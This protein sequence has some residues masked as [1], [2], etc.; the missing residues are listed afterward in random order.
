MKKLSSSYAPMIR[1][2]ADIYRN[3]AVVYGQLRSLRVTAEEW[4]PSRGGGHAIADDSDGVMIN[5]ILHPENGLLS[6]GEWYR[7]DGTEPVLQWP[8][9][10]IRPHPP[11]IGNNR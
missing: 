3:D 1:A 9:T 4:D 10:S 2:I 7:V 5:I 6:W 11:T 8:P